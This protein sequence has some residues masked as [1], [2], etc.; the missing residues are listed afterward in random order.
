M[1]KSILA[2]VPND[3]VD[4]SKSILQYYGQQDARFIGMNSDVP[5]TLDSKNYQPL[6]SLILSDNYGN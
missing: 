3:N 6:F 1:I 2:I 4:I 5:I